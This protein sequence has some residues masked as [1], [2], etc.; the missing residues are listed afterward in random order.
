MTQLDVGAHVEMEHTNDPTVARKIAQ[1]HL[2]EDP[3]YYSKLAK[4][5]KGSP[6]WGW[7]A[8]FRW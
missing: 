4:M 6:L 8:V 2:D 5:E 3:E 1:D 7:D